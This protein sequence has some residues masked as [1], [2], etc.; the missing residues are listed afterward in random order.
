MKRER[1]IIYSGAVSADGYIA[2]RDD[3]VDWLDRPRVAGDYGMGKFIQSIDTVLW[4]R[5][6]WDVGQKLGGSLSWFGKGTKHYVFSKKAK[7][8]ARFTGAELVSGTV[9]AFARK[10]RAAPGK[11]VWLMGGGELAAAFLDAGE[12]DRLDFAVIPTLIGDGI[13][14]L[15]RRRRTVP[16]KLVSTKR[17]SDGVVRVVYDVAR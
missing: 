8:A 13:P 16:L 1:R 17:Y 5:R 11:D 9:R 10:L 7:S 6:T 14:L 12:L 3:A 15:S 2:R 4:G